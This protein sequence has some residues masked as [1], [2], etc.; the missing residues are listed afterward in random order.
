MGEMISGKILGLYRQI[1]QVLTQARSRAW[2]A[3]NYEMVA[4]YWEIGRLIVEEEQRGEARA[5]YGK[6]LIRDLSKRL[7]EEFG[8]GFDKRNL[9]FIR[10][11]YLA[12]PKV[13]ALRSELTW[14]HYRILLRVDTPEARAFYE[15]E[16]VNARWSTR[17][18][19]RQINSLL[20]QRLAL[21]RDKAGV[22][23]LAAKGHELNE[24]GELVK[25]PYVLEFTG[26]RQDERFLEKDLESA[27]ITKLRQFLLELGKG[28]SFV[29]RQKRFTLDGQHF[30]IDLVFY[31]YILKC[32]VLIDLK[33]GALTHQDLGQMQM[34]VNYYTRELMNEG[35]GNP[36]GIVLCSDKNDAVVRYTLPEGNNQIYASRY[37]LYLPSEKELATELLRERKALE[38]EAALAGK[39]R[40][41]R[42]RQKE[43]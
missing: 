7:S 39:T 24:P 22:M 28:F 9:W 13:N 11:F 34:Y 6:R 16:A 35:D 4:C 23:A 15:T 30:F 21:S 1:R 38:M 42:T 41:T 37:K 29:A 20:F 12:Y 14:T 10:S 3:V 27:L 33:V 43:A 36:I 8:K 2:Q 25:D 31:N 18:L 17:E 19:E 40:K 32:F 5:D 26:I